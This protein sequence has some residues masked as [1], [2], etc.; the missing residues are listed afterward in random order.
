MDNYKIF[1]E[2]KNKN[3]KREKIIELFSQL[4]RQNE[5][6]TDLK[7]HNKD[8]LFFAC[9]NDNETL[10]EYLTDNYKDSFKSTYKEC[11]LFTYINRSP[12]IL[13]IALN[14]LPQL[15][16]E[17]KNQYIQR[18]S[19]N[20]YRRENIQIV[21]EWINKNLDLEEK[22]IFINKLYENNNK[23]FLE[24]VSTDPTLKD[25]VLNFPLEKEHQ[26]QVQQYLKR[27]SNQTIRP[28]NIITKL[29]TI[30]QEQPNNPKENNL[31]DLTSTETSDNNLIIRR[32]K[33]LL[34]KEV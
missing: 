25:M 21:T 27:Y 4:S 16:K 1:A 26:L 24:Y 20:C 29:E 31:L 13:E 18:F 11:I 28:S 23:P 30:E 6:I 12:K 19:L 17:E 34:N 7:R 8:L 5:Q 10:F 2:L 3:I 22:Q 15:T 14:S 32:K 33:R 9:F